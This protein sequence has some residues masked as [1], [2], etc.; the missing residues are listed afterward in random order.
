MDKV[1]LGKR[2]LLRECRSTLVIAAVRVVFPWS[3]CPIVPMFMCGL[4]QTAHE[5]SDL[6]SI[7]P[8]IYIFKY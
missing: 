7:C 6:E 3:T 5:S 1:G 4:L 8:C 2:K